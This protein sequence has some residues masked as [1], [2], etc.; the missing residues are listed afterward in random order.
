M[1]A[2]FKHHKDPNFAASF[3]SV[4]AN[5]GHAEPGAGFGGM[6][7]L[8]MAVRDKMIAPNIQ[9]RTM[10]AHVSQ[11]LGGIN[12]NIGTQ[13]GPVLM[14]PKLG[15]M[16]GGVSSFGYSGTI[17]HAIVRVAHSE[18]AKL[19]PPA[20]KLVY[21]RLVFA[22]RE[23]VNVL[24]Q[25]RLKSPDGAVE[26]TFFSPARGPFVKLV[27]DHQVKGHIVFP[28]AGY[29]EMARAAYCAVN[30]A[31]GAVLKR[32][33]FLQPLML[34][35]TDGLVVTCDVDAG[36]ERFEISSKPEDGD[37]VVH[38]AGDTGAVGKAPLGPQPAAVREHTGTSA[39]L[40][41]TALY[42]ALREGGLEY[43]P[44]FRMLARVYADKEGGL[45][46]AH[47][48]RRR[49]RYGTKV[50]PADLDGAIQLTSTLVDTSSGETRLPFMVA[51]ATLASAAG[52]MCAVLQ[53]ESGD[54]TTVMMSD[55]AGK[56]AMVKLSGFESRVLKAMAAPV[57]VREQHLYV[58]QW[59]AL[60]APAAGT[61]TF[62]PALTLGGTSAARL[63]A[64]SNGLGQ[65]SAPSSVL[66]SLTMESG[67][68]SPAMLPGIEAAFDLVRQQLHGKPVPTWLLTS[69]AQAS[70]HGSSAHPSFAGVM[71][72]ARSARQESPAALLSCLDVTASNASANLLLSAARSALNGGQHSEPDMSVKDGVRRVPRLAPAA[73]ALGGPIKLHFDARGAVSNL[74][75]VAQPPDTSMPVSGEA[76]LNIRAV[77]LNFRDV[78]NVLGAYPGDP[79][80][81]GGDCAAVVS[82]VGSGITHIKVGD[83]ALGHGLAA[84][85]SLSKSDGRL[86]AAIDKSLSFD[87][88]CTLPTTWCTVHM[89]LL[90]ARPAAGHDVLLHAGAGGVGLASQEYCHFIGNRAMANVGRPYKHFYLHKMGLTGRAAQL[91]RRRRLCAGRVEAA[92]LRPAA[93]LAQQPVGGLHRVHV[94]AA[95]AGRPPVRD[96]Q[97]G[98]V[99][100]RAARGGVLQPLH[101]DRARLDHRGGASGG[102]AGTLQILSARAAAFTLH[103]LPL[104]TFEMES[105][106]W[107]A[108]RTLQSGHNTGK[109]VVRI[110]S[111]TPRRRTA[112]TSCR[113]AREAWAC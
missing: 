90:A 15:A 41:H 91:A 17:C 61:E 81:P 51:E 31:K 38:C 113:A 97:A 43:G 63:A 94:R 104:Q 39:A 47:L 76:R 108:F 92:R 26:D 34:D 87:Q 23:D 109:V 99:E 79:G 95:A 8:L 96:R 65:P 88:A 4:K 49:H 32:A 33:Y 14:D 52:S 75:V 7:C 110:P 107:A 12:A 46:M 100:L 59:E 103:G 40:E 58:T 102:C 69:G 16:C 5:A 11:A 93:L 57:S 29:L 54:K 22:W 9:L 105:G 74:R 21:R 53:R 67:G 78:L 20:E 60:D 111:R 68:V 28:G 112:P 62:S 27:Y 10:N 85:A 2:A 30:K 50:H 80:P 64:G 82:A 42:T 101:R 106:V 98:G 84:L 18:L 3:T 55:P 44:E 70:S 45:A 24:L 72:L 19:S 66:F 36:G 13:T 56:E 71:G 83:A 1:G 89:S 73:Q 48:S 77:G 37:K 86:L 35:A 25:Q 6:V